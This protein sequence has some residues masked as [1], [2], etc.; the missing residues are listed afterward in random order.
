M[1][2]TKVNQEDGGKESCLD[3]GLLLEELRKITK[4][5]TSGDLT[6]PE[7]IASVQIQTLHALF[8]ELASLAF[9]NLQD[10]RFEQFMRLALKAQSQ[11][12]RTTETL[13]ALKNPAIIAKQLNMASQQVV[14]NGTMQT[15][16]SA[17]PSTS[18]ERPEAISDAKLANSSF[19]VFPISP[20]LKTCREMR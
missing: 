13:T 14:N 19:G 20:T 12:A 9:S 3:A 15:P 10:E 17:P 7:R 5:V 2:G 6:N 1:Q 4:M 18:N 11:C 16:Q 8:T